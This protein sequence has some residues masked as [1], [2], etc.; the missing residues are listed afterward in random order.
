MS[1]VADLAIPDNYSDVLADL[2]EQV[3]AAQ[4][5][6]MRSVNT[7]L[8]KLYWSIGDTILRRQS[9]EGWGA[10]VIDR[11]AADLRAEF[12]DMTGL[13]RSNLHAMRQFAAAYPSV[14]VVQQPVGQLPWGHIVTLIQKLDDQVERDWYAREAAQR[15][16][17]RA[18]LLNQIKNQSHRR[19]GTAPSN[20][21]EVLPAEESE[22]AQELT[23]DPYVFDFL[24]LSGQVS[25]RQL[26]DELMNRLQETLREFGHGFAF[27]G[28][29]VHFEVD[30]DDFYVDLL[31]FHLEQLRYV[32]V[33]LKIGKFT[34]KDV[35]QLGFYV[36]LVD[37]ERRNPAVHAPTVG[38]LLCTEQ[39]AHTGSA[40][41]RGP[42]YR[43]ARQLPKT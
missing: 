14:E 25:E 28:R 6:A 27:V 40:P 39:N 23:K 26:E 21:R 3:R 12:P 10:K 29:Q 13:S 16:W 11:L 8:I 37:G 15:G 22:L 4:V 43:R 20:F 42:S 32:V 30:G 5:R 36:S 35:G 31:L 41:S 2:K 18:V 9:V 19:V 24:D 33:E 1:G 34:P 7:E 17:S 38:I